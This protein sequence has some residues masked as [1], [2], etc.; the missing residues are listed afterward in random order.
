MKNKGKNLG[1]SFEQKFKKD[2][3]KTF[4]KSFLLRLPDNQS[5]YYNS[6]NPC[7][8]LAYN[9]PKFFMIECK[10]IHGNTLPFS[11]I[12]QYDKLISYSGLSKNMIIG[13]LIWWIDLDKLGW[14]PIE[15]IK[16]MKIDLKK[17]IHIN[18]LLNKEYNILEIPS[19]KKRTFLE[20]DYKQMMNL[21]GDY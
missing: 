18:M 1:K 8:F 21:K 4:P 16:K 15:S 14:V 11:N 12:T 9:D 7:D 3:L 17:S 5:G 19:F 20:A 6:S 13:V 2:W 10:S